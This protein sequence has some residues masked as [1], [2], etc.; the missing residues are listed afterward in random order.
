ML[1]TRDGW[2]T[3]MHYGIDA[4]GVDMQVNTVDVLSS[5]SHGLDSCMKIV[6]KKE[7]SKKYKFP[8]MLNVFSFT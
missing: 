1:A 4:V 3:V 5:D 7:I 8:C 2:V 6:Y